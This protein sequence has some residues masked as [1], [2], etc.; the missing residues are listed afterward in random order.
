MNLGE[1][2]APVRPAEVVK[3]DTSSNADKPAWGS[4]ILGMDGL[5]GLAAL[6]VLMGHVGGE[7]AVGV[8]QP[9]PLGALVAAAG[10][11]L[12]LF[13]ALSGFLLYR[14]FASSIVGSKQPPRVGRF[15]VNRALRIYPAY[16]VVL[17]VVRLLVGVPSDPM[18][19]PGQAT[20]VGVSRLTDPLD[21]MANLTLLH[22]LTPWTIGTG[23]AVSWTLTVEL[24][25]YLVMP[26]LAVGAYRAAKRFGHRK[27]LLAFAPALALLALGSVG[28]LVYASLY[29]P[30]SVAEGT[31]LKWG[32]NWMAVLDRSF[33]CYAG[34]FS[35]GMAA[36]VVW[37]MFDT[38]LFVGR[39]ELFRWGALAA[40][41]VLFLTLKG[42]SLFADT[43]YAAAGG[44]LIL[45]VALHTRRGE[46]GRLARLLE[47][48][49]LLN[50]GKVS[51]SLYLWH[52]PVIWCLKQLG[53]RFPATVAG[54]WLNVGLVLAVSLILST[55]T[56]Q[57][58]EKQALKRKK[59]TDATTIKA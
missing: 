24:V 26:L 49:P 37:A 31:F 40:T 54:Y 28:K 45:F 27:A 16:I 55:A 1:T 51:F 25:F 13:F 21:W 30:S 22:N 43:A 11:G 6:T 38:G 56:Y 18:M 10:Q 59:R 23:L 17:I 19:A 34:L 29:N 20:T 58:V 48:W 42:S 46:P 44:G 4:H 12:T 9:G 50:L 33:F 15:L 14:G 36:A 32:A 52:L 53:T 3:R 47:S 7:L 41:G 5:R 35:F 57:L 8:H 39:R 2:D